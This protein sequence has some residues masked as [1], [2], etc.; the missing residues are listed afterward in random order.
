M[1]ALSSSQS[2]AFNSSSTWNGNTPADG[3][4]FTINRGHKVTVNA[5][6]RPT[7]G[8]GDIA[9]YGKLEIGYQGQFRLNGRITIYGNGSAGYFSDGDSNTSGFLHMTAGASMEIRGSDAD[10]HGIWMETQKHCQMILQGTQ[11]NLNTNL[12]ECYCS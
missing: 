7:N 9:L 11:K 2:G 8:Y 4:T 3:D 6:L 1:A 5:D 10:R 12:S